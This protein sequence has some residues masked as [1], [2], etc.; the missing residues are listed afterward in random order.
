MCQEVAKNKK[1]KGGSHHGSVVTNLTSIHEDV[2][3]IHGLIHWVKDLVLAMSCGV[4]HSSD[5]S[6]L[7]LL[8]R[9]SATAP[10]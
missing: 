2:G 3:S 8:Y 6:F 1:K 10:I 9:P 4:G 7:W 5:P